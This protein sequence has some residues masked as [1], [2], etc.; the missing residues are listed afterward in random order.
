MATDLTVY[1]EDQPGTL[2][3][4]GEVLGRAGINIEGSCGFPCEGKGEI[5]LLVADAAAAKRALQ[6]AGIAVQGERQ[7]LVA[8]I[9][10]R[11]GELGKLARRIAD[12]GVNID[13]IYLN[14]NG[15]V[16]LGV[17]DLDKARQAL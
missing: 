3:Q 11:P 9:E 5:H 6:D 17:D 16:V 14:A 2:A 7:V 10:D 15:Q 13:L 12:A 4:L 8:G 1:L